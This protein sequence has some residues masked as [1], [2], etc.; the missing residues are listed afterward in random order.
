ML[1]EGCTLGAEGLPTR[2]AE[3]S[4]LIGASLTGREVTAEGFVLHFAADQGVGGELRRLARLEQEC[5]ASLAFE[6]RDGGDDVTM[7]VNGSWRET[8]W[9][10]A[11]PSETLA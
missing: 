4:A 1:D 8:P 5:C 3:W 7:E 9:R 2:M 11:M 6:V 10:M